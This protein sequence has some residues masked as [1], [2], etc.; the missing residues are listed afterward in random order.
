MDTKDIELWIMN[1]EGLYFWF[2]NQRA[3]RFDEDTEQAELALFVEMNR[4]ELESR[5][6]EEGK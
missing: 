1:D 4:K 5:I 6:L 3:N 2:Q